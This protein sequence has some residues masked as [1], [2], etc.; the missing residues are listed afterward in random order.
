MDIISFFK[1][2]GLN[3]KFL[4]K[5]PYS[6]LILATIFLG[7]APF[8]PQPHA[9]EKIAMLV[10]GSLQRPIDIFDLLMHISP[11]ILLLMKWLMDRKTQ[12]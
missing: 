11:A 9:F 12:N 2:S 8:S 6:M 7:L 4:E 1:I 5:I 10:D 3:M